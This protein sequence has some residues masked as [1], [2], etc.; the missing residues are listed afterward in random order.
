MILFSHSSCWGTQEALLCRSVRQWPGR[1]TF[2]ATSAEP[3]KQYVLGYS[4]DTRLSEGVLEDDTEAMSISKGQE[5]GSLYRGWKRRQEKLRRDRKRALLQL[6]YRKSE[7]YFFFFKQKNLRA[8]ICLAKGDISTIKEKWICLIICRK[9]ISER[10][11]KLQR[12]I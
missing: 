5:G 4:P 3:I 6:I 12:K 2:S 9:V 10:L 8:K 11:W 7:S 1:G